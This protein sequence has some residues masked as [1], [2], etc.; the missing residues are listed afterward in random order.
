MKNICKIFLSDFK[1]LSRNVVAVVVIMGLTIIPSLYAWFNIFSNWDPYGESAT[2]NM[3][4][5]VVSEDEGYSIEGLKINVG[6]S[7]IEALKTNTTIGWVFVDTEEEA[8][9]GAYAGDYYAALVIPSDFTGTLLSFL[10]GEIEHPQIFYYENEKKNAIAPKITSKAQKTVQEQVNATFVSTLAEALIKISG[11]ISGLELDGNALSNV[12]VDNLKELSGDLQMYVNI[13]NSF[14]CITSSASSLIDTTQTV[15]PNLNKVIENG[16][17][18]VN[19]MQSSLIAASG[20]A[21]SIAQM[22]TYSFELLQGSLDDVI[23]MIDAGMANSGSVNN[24]VANSISSAQ[25]IIPYLNQ[26]FDSAV[27]G[28][29][30]ENTASQVEAIQNQLDIVAADLDRLAV[31]SIEGTNNVTELEAKIKNE[32]IVCKQQIAALKDNFEYNVRPKLNETVRSVQNSLVAAESILYGVDADFSDVSKALEGYA[33]TVKQG[34]ATISSS[35]DGARELLEGLGTVISEIEAL[36]ADEQYQKI[37]EMIKTEPEL[38]G[39]FISSPVNLD[40]VEVYPIENYGSAMAPFYTIL[41]LWVGALILVAVIH[42]KVEPEDGITNVK[43]YQRYF[44][45]YI[46]FFL[47]GQA[48][49]LITVLGNLFYV[50]IQCHEPV[51]FWLAASVSSFAFTLFIYSL[52][53]AFGNVG[54]AIA[55]IVMVIQVAGAGCTFPIEVLPNVFRSI[56]KYLPFQFGMNAMKETIGGLYSFDYWKYIGMYGFVIVL[57]LIIGLGLEIP[58]RKLNHIIEESKQK[59]DV[60]I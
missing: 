37:L 20:N 47:I 22:V 13:L 31:A 53:V 39:N 18:T 15:L 24:G 32:L 33:A 11:S 46:T 25:A 30:N 26:I 50:K 17:S 59:S 38:I 10:N 60:M 14:V 43:Q 9:N 44:G 23:R 5:A 51:L 35:A 48:Q 56:Y 34:N 1:R 12:V 8:I 29:N 36:Q 4:I 54:E 19:T 3:K 2:S 41:A 42:V 57:S 40:T 16:E 7:V 21:D 28:W 49:V 6:D 52:T 45:R 55:V 27:S 58:F